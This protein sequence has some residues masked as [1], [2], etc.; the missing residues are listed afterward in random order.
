MGPRARIGLAWASALNVTNSQS[1]FRCSRC[2][3]ACARLCSLYFCLSPC[4]QQWSE[5]SRGSAAWAL[6][7]CFESIHGPIWFSQAAGGSVTTHGLRAAAVPSMAVSA[8]RS[9][10][11]D[12][13]QLRFLLE[14]FIAVLLE[15]SGAAKQ[16]LQHFS[17]QHQVWQQR[18]DT[19]SRQRS[20]GAPSISPDS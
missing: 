7:A 5:Q 2:F 6:P 20:L 16:R 19:V 4:R 3:E 17:K 8:L 12:A 15:P 18:S 10:T 14:F 9:A 13:L 11:G 1:V